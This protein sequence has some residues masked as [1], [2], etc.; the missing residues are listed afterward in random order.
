MCRTWGTTNKGRK[1]RASWT[2]LGPHWG[3]DLQGGI[4]VQRVCSSESTFLAVLGDSAVGRAIVFLG[5]VPV[6]YAVPGDLCV[7]LLTH[8]L[9]PC[10]RTL[11]VFEMECWA[12]VFL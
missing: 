10:W 9:Q 7:Y 4:G 2:L 12:A 6:H 11:A 3:A 5:H 1:G 8:L